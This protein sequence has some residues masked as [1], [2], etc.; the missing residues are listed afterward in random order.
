MSRFVYSTFVPSIERT[1]MRSSPSR[2]ARAVRPSGEIATWLTPDF[3]SPS[4]TVPAGATVFP[5]MVKIEIEPPWR[6]ATSA[7]VPCRL[8]ESPDGPFPVSSVA[9]TAGG[10]ACRSMTESRL[11]GTVFVASAGSTLDD[12]V[13]SARPSSGVM[14]TLNGGPTT[15]PGASNSPITLG[16]DDFRSRMVTVSGFG[17][18]TIFTTPFTRFTL[19]SFDVTAICADAGATK[20]T[21]AS[22]EV[23]SGLIGSPW[24][25]VQTIARG[26]RAWRGHARGWWRDSPGRSLRTDSGEGGIPWPRQYRRRRF[27]RAVLRERVLAWRCARVARSDPAPGAGTGRR[28][29]RRRSPPSARDGTRRNGSG[30]EAAAPAR[31]ARG[32][33]PL[34]P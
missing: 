12:E 1:E 29:S 8:M 28:G 27:H 11:S 2:V 34:P 24:D 16:C 6:L 15:L 26:A 13:T 3:S 5:S 23:N 17:S 7:S 19:L 18:A 33:R 20:K 10:L 9:S 21:R 30:A 32:K 31:R 22:S 25:L 14:A 4:E